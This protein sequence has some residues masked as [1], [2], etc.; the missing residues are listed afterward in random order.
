L[1]RTFVQFIMLLR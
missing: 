1:Y